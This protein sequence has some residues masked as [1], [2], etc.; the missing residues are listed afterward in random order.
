MESTPA[1]FPYDPQP[2]S[3]EFLSL[4]FQHSCKQTLHFFQM[5]FINLS[6]ASGGTNVIDNFSSGNM[7]ASQLSKYYSLAFFQELYDILVSLEVGWGCFPLHVYYSSLGY[8]Y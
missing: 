6:A 8:S 7:T 5:S 3:T 4:K 2:L 1:N